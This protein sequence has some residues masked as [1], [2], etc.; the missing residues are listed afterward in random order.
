MLKNNTLDVNDVD[1]K[2]KMAFHFFEALYPG[3]DWDTASDDMKQIMKGLANIAYEQLEN[4]I[5]NVTPVA[6]TVAVNVV[7]NTVV[8]NT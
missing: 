3:S 5:V 7:S 1:M 6:N 8:A 2:G 4:H